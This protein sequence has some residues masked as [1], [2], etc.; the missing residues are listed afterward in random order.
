MSA[1]LPRF[2]RTAVGEAPEAMFVDGLTFV[3]IS[4]LDRSGS[5]AP[6]HND[7]NL[8]LIETVAAV[9]KV[10]ATVAPIAAA[11]AAVAHHDRRHVA[12]VRPLPPSSRMSEIQ[13]IKE[14]NHGC[15]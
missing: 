5:A 15:R 2:V 8:K 12:I 1:D 7:G 13:P 6:I 4:R 14:H 11:V 3:P 10:H 9:E